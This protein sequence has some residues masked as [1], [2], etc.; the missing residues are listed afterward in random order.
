M[1]ARAKPFG[2]H[3]S[4]SS[5][6]L[7][8]IAEV[9]DSTR[10]TIDQ[11]KNWSPSSYDKVSAADAKF[12]HETVSNHPELYNLIYESIDRIDSIPVRLVAKDVLAGRTGTS[13][14]E[15]KE[16]LADAQVEAERHAIHHEEIRDRQDMFNE[17]SQASGG[18]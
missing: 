3:T 6:L 8:R 13:S 14:R 11:V 18:V 9:G 10:A 12:I 5:E 15:L 1:G 2:I 7:S 17:N 16:A 4:G